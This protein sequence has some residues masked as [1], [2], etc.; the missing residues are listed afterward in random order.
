MA[1][2]K[3]L[4]VSSLFL[5]S[6]CA[7][8]EVPDFYAYV[9]LPASDTGFGVM[10]VSRTEKVIPKDEWAEKRKRGI[11]IFSEDWSIL[12][13]TI[14]KNCI[15]NKCTKTVGALDGLFLALDN[16]LKQVGYQ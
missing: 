11:I 10:T 5:L 4:F 16:A 3:M 8:V 9:N 12:K 14:R 1:K 2:L 13:K 6:S 15:T 7:T